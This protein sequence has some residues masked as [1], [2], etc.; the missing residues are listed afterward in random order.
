MS[1]LIALLENLITEWREKRELLIE[2]PDVYGPDTVIG[3]TLGR[4]AD[5]LEEI[6][7]GDK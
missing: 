6:L 5:R 1:E 4:C 2:G 3:N 7:R